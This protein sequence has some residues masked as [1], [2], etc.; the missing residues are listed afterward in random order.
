MPES[1]IKRR[2]LFLAVSLTWGDEKKVP[3]VLKV[4]SRSELLRLIQF[5]FHFI[6]LKTIS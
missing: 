6:I 4:I 3:L 1:P 5:L 2:K